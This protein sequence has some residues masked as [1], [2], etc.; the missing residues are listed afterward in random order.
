MLGMSASLKADYMPAIKLLFPS[1]LTPAEI[2]M[3]LNRFYDTPEN[4]IISLP[5]AFKI[6]AQRVNG[7][8]DQTIQKAIA[9]I[10]ANSAPRREI[11]D[12]IQS[13]KYSQMPSARV[14]S[15]STGS[16]PSHLSVVNQTAYALTVTFYGPT[17]RPVKISAGQ[18]LKLDLAPGAYR[19]LGRTDIPTVLPF[20]GNDDYSARAG[21]EMT[22][23]V[24][25][26]VA[27]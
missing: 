4:G 18:S 9:D 7:A 12:V 23:Y 17:E 1:S 20:V 25:S 15:P 5:A 3:A 24:K 11:D 19:V 21:Y 26:Q 16:G 6:I 27:P 22:F 8:D 10:R 14:I 2:I 13:G